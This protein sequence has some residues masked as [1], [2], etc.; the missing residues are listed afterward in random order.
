M[1]IVTEWDPLVAQLCEIEE[2]PLWTP[3]SSK[4]HVYEMVPVAFETF[5][6]KVADCPA[7]SEVGPLIVT[8]G[9]GGGPPPLGFEMVTGIDT[10]GAV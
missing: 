9:P 10:G 7:V 6:L 8:L 4:A 1:P 5:A 2:V 3:V